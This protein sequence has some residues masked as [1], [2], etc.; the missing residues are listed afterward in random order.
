MESTA[1]FMMMWVGW[2]YGYGIGSFFLPEIVKQ[3]SIAYAEP[4]LQLSIHPLEL[5]AARVHRYQQQYWKLLNEQ[6][7]IG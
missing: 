4:F 6:G 7:I 1:D 5:Q 3:T 2:K